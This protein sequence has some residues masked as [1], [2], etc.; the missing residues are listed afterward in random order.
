MTQR[1]AATAYLPLALGCPSLDSS[2]RLL[3][4]FASSQ[5][6]PYAG[7]YEIE[8]DGD[9]MWGCGPRYNGGSA[10]G[11]PVLDAPVLSRGSRA[12]A[13]SVMRR[14]SSWILLR[15]C[16]LAGHACLLDLH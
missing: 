4:G 6:T 16:D 11:L 8:C 5:S 15:G 2:I 14:R 10:S 3:R 7:S 9:G 1:P 12:D 13:M